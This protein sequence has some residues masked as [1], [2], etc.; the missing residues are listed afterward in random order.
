MPEIL[1]LSASEC[2]SKPEVVSSIIIA[3][4]IDF[5]NIFREVNLIVYDFEAVL[6]SLIFLKNAEFL[7]KRG[8]IFINFFCLLTIIYECTIPNL[9]NKITNLND[10]LLYLIIVFLCRDEQSILIW[11]IKKKYPQ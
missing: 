11:L 3:C 10:F 7:Y 1:S 5:C 6:T 8:D 9:C 4:P 2:V